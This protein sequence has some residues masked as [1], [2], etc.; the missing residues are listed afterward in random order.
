MHDLYLA[1]VSKIITIL[2]KDGPP[3]SLSTLKVSTIK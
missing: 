2:P 3:A 1:G